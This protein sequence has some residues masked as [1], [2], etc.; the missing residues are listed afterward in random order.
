MSKTPLTDALHER[1]HTQPFSATHIDDV[2]L[3]AMHLEQSRTELLAAVKLARRYV[4]MQHS[5]LAPLMVENNPVSA[6]L[7][8]ID[9]AI[10]NAERK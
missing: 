10:A 1:Y 4:E 8:T 5:S 2:W 7:G 6:H 9:A 3:H